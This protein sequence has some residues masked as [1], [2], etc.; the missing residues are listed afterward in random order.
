MRLLTVNVLLPV[1]GDVFRL[2][3]GVCL[4]ILGWFL[5]LVNFL[6]RLDDFGL[7]GL[8]G[9]VILARQ[10][11]RH[12]G[13]GN[14]VDGDLGLGLTKTEEASIVVIEDRDASMTEIVNASERH[15]HAAVPLEA[16]HLT[17]GDDSLGADLALVDRNGM[18]LL[19]IEDIVERGIKGETRAEDWLPLGLGA[20]VFTLASEAGLTT[21]NALD[22]YAGLIVG[23]P[24]VTSARLFSAVGPASAT[25]L[26]DCACL[27]SGVSLVRRAYL[28]HALHLAVWL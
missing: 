18:Q 25:R 4:L 14:Q 8:L 1:F 19:L 24:L 22:A 16:T 3:A 15:Y 17:T 13:V 27:T 28:A 10:T 21:R 2:L 20:T 26:I 9:L 6:C 23:S 12:H 7:V 11:C 5:D